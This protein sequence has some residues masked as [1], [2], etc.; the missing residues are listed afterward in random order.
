MS[1]VVRLG[2]RAVLLAVTTGLSLACSVDD[3]VVALPGPEMSDDSLRPS[4]DAGVSGAR[5][6]RSDEPT[7]SRGADTSSDSDTDSDTR[8]GAEKTCPYGQHVCGDVCV[9]NNDWRTCGQGCSPCAQPGGGDA[10]CDGVSCGATCRPGTSICHGACVSDSDACIR[11]CPEDTR[12]CHGLCV[13]LDSLSACGPLCL[14][15]PVPR[16]GSAT[17][18]QGQCG[19][20]C[21][22]GQQLCDDA[23]ISSSA[24]CASS[25]PTG[26]HSCGGS[27]ISS[28]TCCSP[29]A[30]GFTCRNGSCPSTCSSDDD[31]LGDHF[32]NN[33]KCIGRVV[34]LSAGSITPTA[35]SLHSD[36]VVRCWGYGGD[37]MFGGATGPGPV[38]VPLP[39]GARQIAIGNREACAVLSDASLWCWGDVMLEYKDNYTA[40]V[41]YPG[42]ANVASVALSGSIGGCVAHVNGSVSCWGIGSGGLLGRGTNESDDAFLAPAL[43]PGLSDVV[44]IQRGAFHMCAR[45]STGAM[46]CWGD[47]SAGAVGTGMLNVSIPAIEPRFVLS[48]ALVTGIASAQQIAAGASVSFALLAGAADD[49]VLLGWGGDFSRGTGPGGPPSTVTPT[50]VGGDTLFRAVSAGGG[51]PF[52]CGITTSGS[53]KCWGSRTVAGEIVSDLSPFDIAGV[54]NATALGV[55]DGFACALVGPAQIQCWGDNDNGQLGNRSAGGMVATAL[56][57]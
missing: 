34:Q 42:L 56:S 44:E 25:C 12:D 43:V 48:P 14:P 16:G 3:R 31:C 41:P 22:T 21:P 23:C 7:S 45:L 13:P 1:T 18:V 4:P 39:L 24:E 20:Q 55:G 30:D 11:S 10:S 46:A 8:L 19:S 28:E 50:R 29:C 26:M 51:S 2:W 32:C 54:Q 49:G 36:G 6:R 47:N 35:C 57:W 5:E 38:V 17:C 53:V 27:C 37:G 40:P 33:G 52:V 9:R 15:C